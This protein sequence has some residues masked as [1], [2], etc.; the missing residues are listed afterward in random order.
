MSAQGGPDARPPRL[1]QVAIDPPRDRLR[2]LY[3]AQGRERA[4]FAALE[5]WDLSALIGRPVTEDAPATFEEMLP[6]WVGTVAERFQDGDRIEAYR[7]YLSRFIPRETFDA[8]L[9]EIAGSTAPG[10]VTET[11]LSAVHGL[12]HLKRIVDA[13]PP[14]DGPAVVL[15]IGGGFSFLGALAHRYIDAPLCYVSIDAVPE[16]TAYSEAYLRS[17]GLDVVYATDAEG[18]ARRDCDCVVAPAW[19]A[20]RIAPESVDVVVNFSSIQEMPDRAARA[21]LEAAPVW[22]RAGG[23]FLFANSREFF[24][25]R[26]YLQRPPLYTEYK[27][28]S[29]RSRT[30]DFPI[31]IF[32]K[33]VDA[34]AW[35]GAALAAERDYYIELKAKLEDQ[36]GKAQ[37][38]RDALRARAA[39]QT[40]SI[41]NRE[42]AAHVHVARIQ[43]LQNKLKT[44]AERVRTLTGRDVETRARFKARLEDQARKAR[45]ELDAL[46]ARVAG[47]TETI[48]ERGEAASVLRA[49]VK[50][51][52][53]KQKAMAERVRTLT[54]RDAETRAS[55][56]AR[57]ED[58]ARKA[59][60]EL[61]ALRARVARQTET[62]RERGEAA[63]ALR[64]RVKDLQTKRKAM[65]ERIQSLTGRDAKAAA[66]PPS[67]PASKSARE[68]GAGG[69]GPKA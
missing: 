50:D 5:R 17:L 29:P 69:S 57:L 10:E 54:D 48:R 38:A 36:V 66:A 8:L 51:L 46:R 16:S 11:D 4:D 33:R 30:T 58:Q 9:L 22:L 45:T 44:M 24:Y 25:K 28:Y 53:T 12:V 68:T 52:Q 64:A 41:R 43:D 23:A 65:A 55:F 6:L 19:A 7:A 56:K 61:D 1:T 40:E 59:R 15:E 63:S 60:T 39:S 26:E 32:R 3:A 67:K 37:A 18:L 21:Y 13:L 35:V 62:I 27:S 47:Q 42:E 20:G 34:P 31:E 14:R 2:E 49:R